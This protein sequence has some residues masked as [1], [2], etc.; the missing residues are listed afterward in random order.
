MSTA[1]ILYLSI[2]VPVAIG[3]AIYTEIELETPMPVLW[4]ITVGFVWPVMAALLIL[5]G[6]GTILHWPIQRIADKLCDRRSKDEPCRRTDNHRPPCLDPWDRGMLDGRPMSDRLPTNLSNLRKLK[7]IED[8]EA[9]HP[10]ES[11]CDVEVNHAAADDLLIGY[12]NDAAITEAY[13]AIEKWY[14]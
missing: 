1:L 11:G 6:I 13:E 2:L 7:L 4:G 14:S 8:L 9:L 3:V 5:C 10:T 12:I